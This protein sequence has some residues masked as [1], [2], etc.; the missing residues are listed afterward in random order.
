MEDFKHYTILDKTLKAYAELENYSQE[1]FNAFK[2]HQSN[3]YCDTQ[4][5][6]GLEL[7]E[8]YYLEY[9]KYFDT[10]YFFGCSF[11]VY[12]KTYND[13]LEEFKFIFFDANE[14]DFIESELKEGVFHSK[15]KQYNAY[16]FEIQIE[17]GHEKDI[18]F[19]LK[20]RLEYLQKRAKE[21]GFV[22]THFGNESYSLC[23]IKQPLEIKKEV[24]TA[25]PKWLPIGV[26]F[27]KG[28]IQNKLKNT[29]ASNIAIEYTKVSDTNYITSTGIEKAADPKN[30]Y[31]DWKKLDLIYD[32]CNDTNIKLCPDFMEAYNK[33]KKLKSLL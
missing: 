21:N 3:E 4:N 11:K 20:R 32:H 17:K 10:D 22:L 7:Y 16:D 13:R 15:L 5:K 23:T 14:T 33:L 9:L 25:L 31:S 18:N 2:D 30:I 24:E 1:Y 19:S 28:D 12:E 29:S 8:N 6:L 27:A 26:G